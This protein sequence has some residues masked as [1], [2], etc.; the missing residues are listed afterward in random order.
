MVVSDLLDCCER[1]IEMSTKLQTN[2]ELLI[3]RE[4][5]FGVELGRVYHYLWTYSVELLVRWQTYL[6]LSACGAQRVELL[7]SAAGAFFGVIQKCL[8]DDCI[9]TVCRL[10]DPA[11][12]QKQLDARTTVFD[13]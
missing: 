3:E 13:L 10:T 4:K 2:E 5:I 8:F 12:Q 9:L 6:E 7:N 11:E 1:E